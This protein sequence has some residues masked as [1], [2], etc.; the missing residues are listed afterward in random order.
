V[1]IQE[2]ICGWTKKNTRLEGAY[3]VDRDFKNARGN[4]LKTTPFLRD[5]PSFLSETLQRLTIDNAKLNDLEGYKI[6]ET[7][8]I[9]A[10]DKG[11][12]NT[13]MNVA[14]ILEGIGNA[15][16]QFRDMD[17]IN[18]IQDAEKEMQKLNEFKK[19]RPL[20]YLQIHRSKLSYYLKMKSMGHK[21]DYQL[22]S[23]YAQKASNSVL[24]LKDYSRHR[25]EINHLIKCLDIPPIYKLKTNNSQQSLLFR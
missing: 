20:R 12:I 8:A 4:A 13:P 17:A 15:K 2:I 21:L 1:I 22:I 7:E 9:N 18:K 5:N 24:S 10:I 14:T 25:E 16:T 19:N 3:Y 23:E 11:I 6:Y